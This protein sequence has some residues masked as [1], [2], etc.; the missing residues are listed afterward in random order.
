MKQ[1]MQGTLFFGAFFGFSGV[2][3]VSVHCFPNILSRPLAGLWTQY[4]SDI[5]VRASAFLIHFD[6]FIL[7]LNIIFILFNFIY[8]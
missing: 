6:L 1:F 7:L 4:F 5:L 8:Y 2:T 3:W